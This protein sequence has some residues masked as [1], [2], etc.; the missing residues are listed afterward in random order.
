MLRAAVQAAVGTGTPFD[1]ELPFATG[2]GRRLWVR[3]QGNAVRQGDRTT[4]LFGAFQ[5]V[6][7]RHVADESRRLQSAALQAAANAIIITDRSGAIE[8]VNPAFTRLTGLTPEEALGRNPRDL[9]KSGK[10]DQAYYRSMW[11][12]ILAGRV[13]RG[14]TINRR[15]DG[16]LYTEEQVITPIPDASGAITH[17]VAIKEDIT[18]RLKLEAQYR[19]AQKMESVGRLA[20]GIAHD[21]NNLLTVITGMSTLVLGQ[22]PAGDP[23]A[24][25]R[26][27]D[28][29]RR[30]A[31]RHADAPVAG[32]Q[33]SAD[34]RA[35]GARSRC[36]GRGHGG[37]A[38]SAAR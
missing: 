31:R 37:P 38:P 12:T 3:I 27:G 4:R 18:D 22:V 17:F 6:S 28:P 9:L 26:D 15:K 20:S 13:W 36:G 19:Q 10:H 21:F 30:R 2:R 33:P 7:E 25:R 29:P 35:A 1:L 16:R 24:R 8:W 5:D 11:E 34:S 14:E 23:I 32:V